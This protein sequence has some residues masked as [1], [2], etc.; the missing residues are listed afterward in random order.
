MI[1]PDVNLLIYAID[2]S[3]PYHK[4][5]RSWWDAALSS[6]DRVGLSFLS[7]VGFIR[8]MTNRHIL[9]SPLSISKAVDYVESWLAQPIVVLGKLFPT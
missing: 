8:L 4:R 3:S 2:D 9:E 6:T 7:V 5:A 1:L